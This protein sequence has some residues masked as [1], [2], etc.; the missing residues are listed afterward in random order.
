V[1]ERSE[2]GWGLPQRVVYRREHALEVLINI[3]IPESKYSEASPREL[4][5]AFS[6]APRMNIKVMLPAID[7]DNETVL[8]ADEINDVIILRRLAT[9]MKTSVPPFAQMHP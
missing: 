7:F 1:A 6:V 2:A 8:E 3:V 5:V 9:K 4:P